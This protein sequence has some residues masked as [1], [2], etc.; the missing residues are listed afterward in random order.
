MIANVLVVGCFAYLIRDA[1]RATAVLRTAPRLGLGYRAYL[2]IPR[3]WGAML[4][5][6]ARP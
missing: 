3:A 5:R 2:L 4:A 6:K 1:V